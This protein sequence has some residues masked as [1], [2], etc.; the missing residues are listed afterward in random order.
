MEIKFVHYIGIAIG[1]IVI[2]LSF[3]LMGTE[4]FFFLIGIGII[5]GVAPFVFTVIIEVILR[6]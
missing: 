5:I 4:W 2:G 6:I 1:L 3:L